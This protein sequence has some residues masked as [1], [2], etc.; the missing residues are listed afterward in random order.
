MD[1]GNHHALAHKRILLQLRVDFRARQVRHDQCAALAP[2]E[3]A[4][5]E[6]EAGFDAAREPSV[7]MLQPLAGL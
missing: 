6:D 7:V 2:F 3:R 5:K 4:G 1:L